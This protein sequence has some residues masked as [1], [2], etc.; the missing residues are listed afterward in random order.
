MFPTIEIGPLVLP[1]AGVVY[2][3]GIWLALSLAERSAFR[4]GLDGGRIYTLAFVGLAAGLVGARLVFV[5]I[6]W[7]AY[8]QHL[9]SII[10]P[11]TSGFNLWGGLLV[12]SAAAFFYGRAYRLDLAAALDALAPGL[13]AGLMVVSL[14]DFL[15]GSGHGVETSL[16]WAITQFGVSRHPVQLYELLVGAGALLLWRWRAGQ[17]EIVPGRLFLLAA[18][19]YSAG[20]LFTDVF[21]ANPWVIGDGYRLG[22]LIAWLILVLALYL[23]FW[24]TKPERP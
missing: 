20:R 18:A 22:Q 8:S 1:T 19:G 7:P 5:A 4:L 12:G 15:A 11:P 9:W 10:W 6:Y 24:Q 2:I 23:L 13:V 16:F 14:A 17:G 3:L 21:R